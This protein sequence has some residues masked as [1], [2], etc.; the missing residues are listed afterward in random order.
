MLRSGGRLGVIWTSRDREHDWVAELDLLR[1][2]GISGPD[3]GSRVPRTLD[4]VRAQLDR[5]HS[6]A[7]P[8]GAE[9]GDV[10]TASFR[11]TRSIAISDAVEWL[12]TNSAFITASAAARA[13]GIARCRAALLNVT[14]GGETIEMPMRSWCWRANRVER[15]DRPGG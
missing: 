13:E 2:P 15:A 3:A 9:F 6:V 4:D 8:A 7:L 12:A 1:L 14:G 5:D 11:F 10:E